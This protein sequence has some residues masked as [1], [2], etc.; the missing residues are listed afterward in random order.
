[1]PW[2]SERMLTNVSLGSL[3]YIIL[4]KTIQLN[5]S[6]LQDG[7]LHSNCFAAL[8]NMAPSV[9]HIHSYA[10]QRLMGVLYLMARKRKRLTDTLQQLDGQ[11]DAVVVDTSGA[12]T[13]E[14]KAQVQGVLEQYSHFVSILLDVTCVALAPPLLYANTDL[15]YTLI[16]RKDIVD[17][18]RYDDYAPRVRM[19][20]ALIQF[21]DEK[22]ADQ[23]GQSYTA[24]AE[25]EV[26][27]VLQSG[28]RTWRA[29][30]ET[31]ELLAVSL[32]GCL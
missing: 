13:E 11:Q 9:Q 21:F 18:L 30:E 24:L 27:Q 2:F 20:E 26:V 16:H 12:S 8:A 3:I 15:V 5:A 29:N 14:L 4:L 19:L 23:G 6:K 10:S 32:I 31:E 17:W 25:E 22:L 28:V 7:Y 1:M